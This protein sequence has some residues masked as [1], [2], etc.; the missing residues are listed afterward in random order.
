MVAMKEREQ[1]LGVGG[2]AS[3]LE[4]AQA[5]RQAPP[6][7]L[8]LFRVLLAALS[9]LSLSLPRLPPLSP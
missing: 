9:V 6:L 7:L 8:Y 4:Q 3:A 2:E 1:E 5:Q